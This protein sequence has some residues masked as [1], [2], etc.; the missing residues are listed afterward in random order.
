MPDDRNGW[1]M[2]QVYTGQGKG[3]TTAAIGLAMRAAGW[4]RRVLIVQFLKGRETGELHSLERLSPQIEIVQMGTGG[5][6]RPGE[7]CSDL[8]EMTEQGLALACE[9]IASGEYHLVVLDEVLVAVHIGLLALRDVLQ[10][11]REKPPGVE[12]VL[13]GRGAAPEIEAEADLVTYMTEVKHPFR[14]GIE[15]R[16]GVDY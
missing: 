13:T 9:A 15:A 3:K 2:V 11:I 5:F 7:E 4:D 12:L 1:G 16:K 10:L 8:K 6:L 14:R